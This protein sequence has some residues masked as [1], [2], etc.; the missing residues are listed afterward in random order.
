MP[1]FIDY[2]VNAR[3]KKWIIHSIRNEYGQSVLNLSE[4]HHPNLSE[5]QQAIITNYFLGG[6]KSDEYFGF[7]LDKTSETSVY[8]SIRSMFLA[9]VEF[10]TMSQRIVEKF[11]SC[12]EVDKLDETFLMCAEFEGALFNGEEVRAIGVFRASN[13]QKFAEFDQ[14]L[15]PISMEI[16][17]GHS[18][19]KPDF[20]AVVF[21]TLDREGYRMLILDPDRKGAVPSLWSSDFLQTKAVK[22]GFGMTTNYMDMCKSFIVE[23]MPKEFEMD[24]ATQA[25]FLNK[26]SSYFKKADE[27]DTETFVAEVFEQSD[28]ID[29]F[30][31]FKDQF[32]SERQ[33]EIDD[34]FAASKPAIRQGN[35][36]FKSVLKLDKNF[37]VYVHGNREMI[38]QGF[39]AERGLKFYKIFFKEEK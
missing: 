13:K 23:Q 26:S 22:S 19:T 24:R 28:I 6:F 3:I 7:D 4:S 34:R 20:A 18:L 21:D 5:E 35:K 38:E 8:S 36:D 11:E 29:S 33:I 25:S 16:R 32:V 31:K 2:F 12:I 30:D 37:H 1:Q 14:E 27:I 39:D 15:S 9:P 17:T 10:V